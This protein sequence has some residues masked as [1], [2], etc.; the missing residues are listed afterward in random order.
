VI[1]L[2]DAGGDP[3]TGA[4]GNR[5]SVT[6]KM[7]FDILVAYAS[8]AVSAQHQGDIRRSGDRASQPGRGHV[9][10]GSYVNARSHD[11]GIRLRI[12]IDA[13][14]AT[15]MME[16]TTISASCSKPNSTSISFPPFLVRPFA[17]RIISSEL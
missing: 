13:S 15:Q 1:G 17:Q 7:R 12:S 3:I 5:L 16:N 8:G 14:T 6:L 10:D 9:G 11:L 4:A 2:R